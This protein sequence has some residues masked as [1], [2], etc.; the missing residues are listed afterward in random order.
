M[1]PN[2]NLSA[3]F[4]MFLLIGV[5]INYA[6]S[7]LFQKIFKNIITLILNLHALYYIILLTYHSYFQDLLGDGIVVMTAIQFLLATLIRLYF[8]RNGNVTVESCKDLLNLQGNLSRK[9]Q[10]SRKTFIYSIFILSFVAITVL[11]ISPLLRKGK[12]HNCLKTEE[13][14][15]F[16]SPASNMYLMIFAGVMRF[17]TN[18]TT[19]S[20]TIFP[21]ILLYFIYRELLIT[22]SR[23]KNKIKEMASRFSEDLRLARKCEMLL[24]K[25]SETVRKVDAAFSTV[26]FYMISILI[27]QEMVI[28]TFFALELDDSALKLLAVIIGSGVVLALCALILIASRI[29]KT[30][31]KVKHIILSSYVMRDGTLPIQ[32]HDA[33]YLGLVQV[34]S[35]LA[36]SFCI[37]AMDVVKID[38]STIITILCGFISYGVILYQMF[39][40]NVD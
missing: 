22:V 30:Y 20:A 37:T 1:K 9:P 8:F 6:D 27:I 40:V 36:E 14:M 4:N 17:L 5:N 21:L 25:A 19:L 10:K 11:A 13:F 33:V 28:I 35:E 15:L 3:I 24:F 7:S 2:E 29:P 18:W 16:S 23:V 32:A 26:L 12:C 31:S 34:A 39:H 38:K